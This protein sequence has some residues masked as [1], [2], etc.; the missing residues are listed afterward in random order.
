MVAASGMLFSGL[1]GGMVLVWDVPTQVRKKGGEVWGLRELGEARQ[2]SGSV[3]R[4]GLSAGG[5]GVGPTSLVA[6][7]YL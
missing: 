5:M 4:R 1:S 6:S 2:G 3:R 7:R